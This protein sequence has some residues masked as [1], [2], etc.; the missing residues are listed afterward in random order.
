M[1][2]ITPRMNQ[3][4]TLLLEQEQPISVKYLAERMGLS[5]RTIQRELEYINH[6]LQDYPIQFL[7]KTG[8]GIWLDGDPKEKMSLKQELSSDDRLDI[9]NREERRKAL[10]LAILKEKEL[11]KLYYYSS[12]FQVSEAT[13]SADLEAIEGWLESYGLKITRKQGSGIAISGEEEDYRRAI[14]AFINENIDTRVLREAYDN[15][16]PEDTACSLLQQSEIGKL[17]NDKIVSRVIGC[18]SG[19]NNNRVMTLTENSYIGLVIHISIA[20]NRIMKNEVLPEDEK[21]EHKIAIDEDYRLAEQIVAELEEEFEIDIPEVEISYIY[22]HIKGSKHEKIEWEGQNVSQTESQNLQLLLNDMIDAFDPEKAYWLKQDNEF[23]QGLLAHLQPTLIRLTHGMQIQNPVLDDIKTNY[24]DIYANCLHVAEV[25]QAYT[26]KSVPEEET[27]FL[28]VHFGAAVFRMEGRKEAVRK[29]EVGIICSSGIGISRLMMS[30]LEKMF[31]DRVNLVTYGKNDITPYI[32][33]KTDF[34]VSSIELDPMDIPVISV[35]PLLNDS[36]IEQIRR[37]L[38]QYERM[39]SKQKKESSD[40]FSVEL[41]QINQIAAQINLIIKHMGF[42]KVSDQI[43]FDELLLAIGEHFSPYSDQIKNI[44]DDLYRREQLSTQIFA[45]FGFGLLHTRTKGVTRPM[46]G[47]C[48]TKDLTE[49]K[50]NYFKGIHV[51]FV[52]LVPVDD[53]L[54]IN[55]DIMGYISGMLIEDPE[56]LITAEHGDK[57]EIREMLSKNLKI[58]FK[59]YLSGLS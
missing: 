8:V 57:E 48:M 55:N 28:T 18:L 49:F 7:S 53:L 34:F 2:D 51:I 40:P 30:K 39:P 45:E 52:M 27:G 46:F 15:V 11:R 35:N 29:V 47:V 38:Y 19:M 37:M 1:I 36:D 26:G 24:P 58:Y 33:G 44:R 22:L 20:I 13:I 41:D 9:S 50:D 12:R 56:F 3:I 31:R 54:K 17:L 5:K 32:Q 16:N 42:F 59:K 6:V 23:I 43:S 4:L 10:I 21:W 14:R 25:L